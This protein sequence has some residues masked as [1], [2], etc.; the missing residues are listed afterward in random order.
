M[1]LVGLL[2]IPLV[3]GIIAMAVGKGQLTWK[4]LLV[5]EGALIALI[6]AFYFIAVGVTRCSASSDTEIWNG[7]IA[8][9]FED[10][11]HCCHSYPCNCRQVCSGT[12]KNR[13]CSTVCDTCYMHSHDIYWQANSSNGETV[14]H[15]GCNAPGT[16]PPQRWLQ[17]KVGEPTAVE[18]RFTNYIKAAPD[19]ILRRQGAA[20][21]FA[22][23]LPAYP[24]VYDHYRVRRFLFVGVPAPP[25]LTALDDRL[26]RINAELGRAKQVN[27]TV[28]VVKTGDQQYL[29]ALTEHW[30]GGKK[31]DVVLVIG[32]P[33]FPELAW[34]GVMSW[35]QSEEMKLA[36]RDQVMDLKQFDGEQILK[37]L[38]QQV[39]SKFV[40]KPMKDFEYLMAQV[41]PPWWSLLLI[42]VLGTIVSVILTVYFLK[43]DPFGPGGSRRR[44]R[45]P[46]FPSFGRFGRRGR[47]RL[48]W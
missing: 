13:S 43:N 16:S 14:F 48:P 9:K 36:I 40:R 3:I 18:H 37:I 26:D 23:L 22:D 11:E 31:N 27:M 47:G 12:G 45:W 17:I 7:V 46:R 20:A 25:N 5:Q 28:V 39:N 10:T 29:E 33:K 42:F 4:E 41:D 2:F 21:Q 8:K 44:T 24:R 15:D 6:V 32:A 35:S 30:L 1:V 34:A 19:T 38:D